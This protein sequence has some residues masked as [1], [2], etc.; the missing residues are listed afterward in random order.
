MA[1]MITGAKNVD[2]ALGKSIRLFFQNHA[3]VKLG[4]KGRAKGTSV[5]DIVQQLEVNSFSS[6][7]PPAFTLLQF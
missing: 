3:I 1:V 5:A 4:V 6:Y 2:E 7:N